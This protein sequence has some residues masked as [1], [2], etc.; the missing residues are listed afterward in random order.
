MCDVTYEFSR[1]KPTD[2]DNAVLTGRG[3]GNPI[4]ANELGEV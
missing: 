3:E 2:G 4:S 1:K